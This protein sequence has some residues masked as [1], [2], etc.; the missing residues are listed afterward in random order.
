MLILACYPVNFKHPFK[1]YTFDKTEN[2]DT[3][4]LQ[5]YVA[6][7]GIVA[8]A[9]YQTPNQPITFVNEPLVRLIKSKL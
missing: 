6:S 4:R 7:S 8:V 3:K 9:V 1:N 5:A 2:Q